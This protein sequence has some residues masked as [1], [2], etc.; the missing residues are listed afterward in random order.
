MK[1]ASLHDIMEYSLHSSVVPRL[2]QI[3]PWRFSSKLNKMSPFQR[4][5]N[6]PEPI[7]LI[8]F[9]VLKILIKDNFLISKDFLYL[10]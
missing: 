9:S 3:S 2:E 7:L 10:L 4:K 6:P 8:P 5:Q 1:M